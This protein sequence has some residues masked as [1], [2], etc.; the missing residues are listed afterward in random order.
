MTSLDKDNSARG[1]STNDYYCKMRCASFLLLRIY[2]CVNIAFPHAPLPP[3]PSRRLKRLHPPKKLKSNSSFP[4]IQQHTKNQN[5]A[6]P[7][8]TFASKLN[9]SPD[10]YRDLPSAT[11]LMSYHVSL[12]ET[13]E[14]DLS[15][16][17]V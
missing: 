12:T 7:I 3:H 6:N 5:K 17:Q 16:S 11:H 1:R 13:E 8:A 10:L 4:H 14:I 15:R 9:H 2:A